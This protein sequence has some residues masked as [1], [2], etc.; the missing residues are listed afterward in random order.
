MSESKVVLLDFWASWCGPCKVMAPVIDDIEEKY[1]G[2]I[3]IKKMEVDDPSNQALVDKYQVMS[4]PT[5]LIEKNG[6]VVSQLVG[7]QS[8]KA[9][10]E[11][12][13]KAL[14]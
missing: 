11:E 2:K 8:K 1:K 6:M 5:Y 12:L 7:A 4:I 9:I 3:T 13:D 10:T 14:E